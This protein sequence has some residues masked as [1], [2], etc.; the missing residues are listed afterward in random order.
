[1]GDGGAVIES[2]VRCDAMR[3]D[4]CDGHGGVAVRPA[5]GLYTARLGANTSSCGSVKPAGVKTVGKDA[6]AYSRC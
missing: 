2:N 5:T 4:A 1:M 6:R 3:C